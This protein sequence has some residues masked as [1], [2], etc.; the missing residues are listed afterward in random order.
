[1]STVWKDVWDRRELLWILCVRN[2]KIRYKNSFLG[3]FWSLLSP[4][5]MILVY[6][7]FARILRF[8][9]GSPH[10]LQFLVTGLIV[11]QFLLLC[12]NDSLHAV[13]GSTNLIKKTAFPRIILPLSTVAAN[14][15]NFLLTL[16]VLAVFLLF[17]HMSFSG[18]QWLPL[19]VLTHTALCLGA[20]LVIA[21][22]NVFFRDTQHILQVVTLAWF[23]LTPIFYT[24]RMQIDTLPDTLRPAAFLNPM[25]GLVCA[26]RSILMAEPVPDLPG[27]ALSLCVCWATLLFGLWMF[28]RNETRFGDEL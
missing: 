11:W 9:A 2:L 17:T 27:M 4:L 28:R 7:I 20:G 8:S 19:V 3:F 14:L 16:A 6:A 23:F 1:M 25:T 26:Y 12:L 24:L 13:V 18:L 5:F 15:L 22:A 10:Y 21:T